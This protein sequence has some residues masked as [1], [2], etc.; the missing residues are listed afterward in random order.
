MSSG[1]SGGCPRSLLLEARFPPPGAV[2]GADGALPC[3]LGEASL[4]GLWK[5]WH[6]SVRLNA[7]ADK[8]RYSELWEEEVSIP[9]FGDGAPPHI[10]APRNKKQSDVVNWGNMFVDL[11]V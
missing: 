8:I 6:S 5:V 10:N 1:F 4:P 7:Y 11:S 9:R 3:A 2:L